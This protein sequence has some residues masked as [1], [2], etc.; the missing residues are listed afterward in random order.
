MSLPASL[1]GLDDA[2]QPTLRSSALIG[3]MHLLREIR[4]GK[5]EMF[6]ELC[7]QPDTCMDWGGGGFGKCGR[8]I[9]IGKRYALEEV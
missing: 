4:F 6:N 1:S 5:G 9:M 7:R 2:S 8:G 3:I